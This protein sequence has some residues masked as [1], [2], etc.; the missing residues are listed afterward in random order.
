MPQ[1]QPRRNLK[2]LLSRERC[3][4]QSSHNV[5]FFRDCSKYLIVCLDCWD[6]LKR[7]HC[8]EGILVLDKPAG[9]SSAR[10]VARVKRLLP[11][12]VPIM[13]KLRRVGK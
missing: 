9:I 5:T 6:L 3:A 8:M 11:R 1:E 12:E 7:L 13:D 10:A 2:I 4:E